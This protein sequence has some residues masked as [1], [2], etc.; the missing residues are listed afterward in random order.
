MRAGPIGVKVYQYD[1]DGN[2]IS[3]YESAQ[4]ASELNKISTSY[5]LSHLKGLFS[6]C[7]NYIFTHTYYI[8][9]PEDLLRHK[10]KRIYIKKEI[11]QYSKD[12]KYIQSFKDKDEASKHTGLKS[13]Y[14][15]DYASGNSGKG[16]TYGGFLWSF[17]KKK[18]ISKFEKKFNYKQ[19]HQYSKDGK[20]LKSYNS[21]KE[22]AE[23]NNLYSSSIS[24]CAS[25]N[26]KFPT[27]GGFIWSYEKLKIVKAVKPKK[28]P[29]KVYKNNKLIKIFESQI[30]VHKELGISRTIIFDCV[31]GKRENYKDYIIKYKDV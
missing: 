26:K 29:I 13:R 12:G 6:Y 9:L 16:K 7:H 14:I 5:L 20:F 8:K 31:S 24:H 30:Q 11:H 4:A 28:T 21:I 18:E 25:G 22:A 15:R 27:Y 1:L 2:F 19:I 23:L 3:E 17:E 10:S